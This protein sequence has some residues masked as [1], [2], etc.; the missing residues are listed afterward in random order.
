[1]WYYYSS[2][3]VGNNN[4]SNTYISYV[5]AFFSYFKE[6]V[7]YT[8]SG[9]T[10]NCERVEADPF[11]QFANYNVANDAY[12]EVTNAYNALWNSGYWSNTTSD[13]TDVN[14][15]NHF[16]RQYTTVAGEAHSEAFTNAVDRY[17]DACEDA[18]KYYKCKPY[19]ENIGQY[20][21]ASGEHTLDRNR[22]YFYRNPATNEI[23]KAFDLDYMTKLQAQTIWTSIRSDLDFIE[24]IYGNVDGN[25][26]DNTATKGLKKLYSVDGYYHTDVVNLLTL[27]EDYYE[28]YDLV[29]LKQTID[30]YITDYQIPT[31]DN[32]N[33]LAPG[34]SY[35]F[36]DNDPESATYVSDAQI[37]VLYGLF[38]G[39]VTTLSSDDTYSRK[40]K[41]YVFGNANFDEDPDIAYIE[42]VRDYLSYEAE[43]RGFV[44]ELAPFVAHFTPLIYMNLG[45][46][47]LNQLQNH[48][49]EDQAIY[50]KVYAYTFLDGQG[51][52]M[53]D[54][55]N[56][57]APIT[58]EYLGYTESYPYN[59][60]N[61]YN[62]Y[63]NSHNTT[64]P[65]SFNS[66]P[67]ARADF[68]ALLGSFNEDV[69]YY[70]NRLYTQLAYVMETRITDA[71][72]ATGDGNG[73]I[74]ITLSNF[75]IIKTSLE[76]V[77]NWFT[78]LQ[79]ATYDEN[80]VQTG[81]YM[82]DQLKNSCYMFKQTSTASDGH[83]TGDF[84]NQKLNLI[85]ARLITELGGNYS[86][87]EAYNKLK[88]CGLLDKVQTFVN[89]GG[90]ANWAQE[91]YYNTN[92][93]NAT[94]GYKFTKPEAYMVRLPYA[95]DLGRGNNTVENDTYTVTNKMV[96]DLV[97]QL[98]SFLGSEDM[99]AILSTFIKLSDDDTSM[100]TNMK[101]SEYVMKLLGE[102]LFTDNI[103]NA[104]INLAFPKIT[105]MLEDLWNGLDGKEIGKIIVT[106]NLY[107]SS[108]GETIYQLANNLGLS[109]YPDK[110]A[111]CLTNSQLSSAR[112][113]LADTTII[114]SDGKNRAKDWENLLAKH[115]Y[116]DPVT[117]ETDPEKLGLNWGVSDYDYDTY[118]ATDSTPT[119]EE[120]FANRAARF[121]VALS[122]ILSGLDKLITVVFSGINYNQ[123]S[124][125]QKAAYVNSIRADLVN[126]EIQGINGYSRIVVPL[127]EMLGCDW[128][129]PG[130]ITTAQQRLDN[131]YL[132]EPN[133]VSATLTTT[134]KVVDAIFNPIVK[135]VTEDVASAPI[136]EILE[137]LPN[138]LYF[139]SFGTIDTLLKDLKIYITNGKLQ[140]FGW[141]LINLD[142]PTIL[143]WSFVSSALPDGISSDGSKVTIELFKLLGANSINELIK[144]VD[145]SDINA[146]LSL[147]L[148]S[149]IKDGGDVEL[150]IVDVGSVL[151]RTVLHRNY[152]TKALNSSGNTYSRYWFETDK[153]D[154]FYDI[155]SWVG[156]AFQNDSFINQ[157]VAMITKSNQEQDSLV[158]ELLTGVK[159]A[160]PAHFVMGLVEVFQPKA[161]AGVTS[162][163][164]WANTT[165]MP[166]Q[167]TWYGQDSAQNGMANKGVSHF[168]YVAYQNDWTYVKA[169]TFV[170]NADTIITKLLE[171]Q[172]KEREVNSFGEWLLSLINLA[173][174]PPRTS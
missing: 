93:G 65:Y 155:I 104:L 49:L 80:D 140:P 99:V 48:V 89:S 135:F 109:V 21:L 132:L 106:F 70:I 92:D 149:V 163:S 58:P 158:R 47:T 108:K 148:T 54:T 63:Y 76:R 24:V 125:I 151:A 147:V 134:S 45:S 30:N 35:K 152:T 61:V 117:G 159:N 4:S 145:I 103:I 79:D 174:S 50:E 127:L 62:K 15:I 3:S 32:V 111:N 137:L 164:I 146:I 173:W 167:Y 36:R 68:L 114:N 81:V 126:I 150:P 23:E 119:Y 170:E 169:N 110:L 133:T 153:A 38:R 11:A 12:N 120:W 105:S 78:I 77:L 2:V 86:M 7:S 5:K 122:G 42:T 160:G 39:Y 17:K 168:L 43:R 141:D 98:D 20:S 66:N 25:V 52:Q 162:T 26:T 75:S 83:L 82:F 8:V 166:A 44:L 113:A 157:L 34:S 100:L 136:S 64:D 27:L 129:I 85:D 94:A 116:V 156:K 161:R 40:L 60:I 51:N 33:L 91:H 118:A 171:N 154:M 6:E 14:I 95:G 112:A 121:K 28:Y 71:M 29:Q 87:E 46:L 124:E 138:L 18:L 165:Y 1:M 107:T 41:F 31:A 59:Y 16:S 13:Q 172:L 67:L 102:K 128:S 37:D 101:L 90:L 53:V 10:V 143:G 55:N 19:A 84:T 88:N 57:N 97:T 123:P 130:N 142:I 56:G 73:N 139:L 69:Q 131:G 115:P 72:N 22:L 9:T 74:T 144:A 96:N